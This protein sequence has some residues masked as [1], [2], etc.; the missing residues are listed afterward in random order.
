MAELEER[1][2]AAESRLA[3]VLTRLD[4]AEQKVAEVAADAVK[5]SEVTSNAA[6]NTV[7]K[8]GSQAQVAVSDVPPFSSS[9]TSKKYVDA[10]I[11]KISDRVKALEK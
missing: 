11:K 7:A 2:A 3:D 6:P 5:Q 9:A 8:R 10:E 1:I 4:A